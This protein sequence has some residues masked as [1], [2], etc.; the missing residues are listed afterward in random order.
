MDKAPKPVF[1]IRPV[2]EL[3]DQAA[4]IWR[5][6]RASANTRKASALLPLNMDG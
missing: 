4:L 5:P 6:R 2:A 3:I 1:R